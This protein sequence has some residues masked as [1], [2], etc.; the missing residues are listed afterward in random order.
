MSVTEGV[1]SINKAEVLDFLKTSSCGVLSLVDGD[2][3]YC[4]PVEHYFDGTNLFFVAGVQKGQRKLRCIKNNSNACYSIYESRRETPEMVKKGTRCRS[5]LIEGSISIVATR[6]VDI[7]GRGK[8]KA[9]ILKLKTNEIG[10]W[11]C[12]GQTCDW[13]S[14]WFERYPDLIKGL[15]KS[16][17]LK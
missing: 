12:P 7:A 13:Q 2:K 1:G 16:S 4:V 6:E 8:V 9:N 3:P 17:Q 5:L 14:P 10:N 11:K 15:T